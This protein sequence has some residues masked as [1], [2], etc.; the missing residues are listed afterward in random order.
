MTLEMHLNEPRTNHS[1][2]LGT[3]NGAQS[4][5]AFAGV[6]HD[7]GNLIQIASAALSL[8]TR[9]PDMP[10]TRREPMLVKACSSLE[11]AGTLV[12]QTLRVARQSAEGPKRASVASCLFEIQTLVEELWGTAF[13]LDIWIEVNLPSVSCDP[14]SL[15]NA[16]LNLIYNAREAMTNGGEV[17]V[18][19]GRPLEGS[20]REMVEIRVA[21]EGIGMSP[22]TVAQ[23]FEP[24]FTTKTEGMGGVGLPMVERFVHAAGGTI[25]VESAVGVGTT[26]IVRLPAV[27][28]DEP[29]EDLNKVTT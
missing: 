27:I 28:D 6:V 15:Q 24:F 25:I 11:H 22:D 5:L 20:L 14:L 8:V 12:R 9:D 29:G 21:D 7:L 13:K 3:S 23:A 16:I 18:R 10:A 19:A 2:S 17:T 4:P 26:M 1:T